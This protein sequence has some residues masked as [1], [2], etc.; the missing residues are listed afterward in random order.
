MDTSEYLPMFLAES[1]E[2]LQELNL[3]VVRIEENPDDRETV[4]EIFRIAHSL[5]GMS[6]TMGFAAIA[7]LTHQMEDVF[8]LLRQRADGLSREAIDV[9]FKC[10]DALEAAVEE[11]ATDGAE[12]LEPGPLIEQLKG[13][14][15]DRTPEQELDRIG[16]VELPD[17][18]LAR[19][20]ADGARIVHVVADLSEEA[21]MP[22]VR[23]F[24]FFAAL[25]ELGEIVGSIP[26]QDSVEQFQG[27]RLEAWLASDRE[28]EV[29]E[30]AARNV[31]DVEDVLLD[32]AQDDLTPPSRETLA[33][34]HADAE[35]AVVGGPPVLEPPAPVANGNGTAPASAKGQRTAAANH[36]HAG[37]TVR[38]DAERLDQLMHHMGELVIH[39]TVVET[40]ANDAAVPG[41]QQ[42][43]Q[44]LARSSQALQ[45]MVMQVRMIPV[46]AVFLRFPRLVRDLSS[47]LSKEV[48][49]QLVGQET[50]LDRTVVDALGD[51]LV[52]LVRN[53]L[54]HGLEPPE[55]REAAGKPRTGVLEISARHAGGNVIISVRDDG[56][57]VDPARVAQKAFERGLISEEAIPT[58]DSQRAAELLFTAGFST[59]EQTSD[60]SGRGVGMDAVQAKIRELGGEVIVSSEL[61]EG[62]TA[63]IRLPLTLAIMAALLVEAEAVPFAIPLDRVERTL[64]LE[65][66]AVRS[67][68][69][70]RML[71]LRDGV[72]PLIDA[73]EALAGRIVPSG[74]AHD[75]AVIVRG[76]DRRLA[77]AV[78]TLVGQRE[79]VTRPLPPE[80]SDRAAVSG[81]AVLSNGE[82]AL[83]VDCDALTARSADAVPI[84]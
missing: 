30:T 9:L 28:D 77:L 43:I 15:R 41:L 10:L 14:I 57:G 79:L 52:H 46:E 36:A 25:G 11:I 27:S 17:L 22:A 34:A 1:R 8:E 61:G 33:A 39:R 29:I 66:H 69:G 38:V 65:D 32:E 24:M 23:A 80:V 83:I 58:I 2:H 5:K 53:A 71:V 42:A 12:R 75:H 55:E 6:A 74:E 82:I 67:V 62:M 47:K 76:R 64:R 48:E 81:G 44:D 16:G 56:R 54:D 7:R 49:L 40:L 4:D 60:I 59:A 63:Q 68:A 50:E 31:S 18:P 84:A 13:L 72:L 35:P 37:A 78:G 70:S 73:G 26:A 51:P 19:E 21:L 3:A 45:A 20:L